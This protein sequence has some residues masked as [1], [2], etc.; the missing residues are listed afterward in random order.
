[1]NHQSPPTFQ[2]WSWQLWSKKKKKKCLLAHCPSPGASLLSSGLYRALNHL[3][4]CC[5]G[6]CFIKESLFPSLIFW[7]GQLTLTS[8]QFFWQS[9]L[10]NLQS[11][12]Y[13]TGF[14][15]TTFPITFAFLACNITPASI[16]NTWS[17]LSPR[18]SYWAICERPVL[19]LVDSCICVPGYFLFPWT[20][21]GLHGTL[22]K[23]NPLQYL[24]DYQASRDTYLMK[25]WVNIWKKGHKRK[26][27]YWKMQQ[28]W[29]PNMTRASSPSFLCT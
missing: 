3:T 15:Y 5:Q 16:A 8:S 26:N 22:K 18:F 25:E 19:V 21:R 7:G 1:M 4:F 10:S 17:M 2:L 28:L 12:H 27:R 14:G 20:L 6:S 9:W 23:L 11:P 24:T 29:S 13:K